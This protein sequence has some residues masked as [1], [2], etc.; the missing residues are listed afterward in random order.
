MKTPAGTFE[1]SLLE[2]DTDGLDPGESTSRYYAPGIG[3]IKDDT[4]GFSQLWIC[5]M[6]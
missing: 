5:E 4:V 3:Q 1:N 6:K 2:K